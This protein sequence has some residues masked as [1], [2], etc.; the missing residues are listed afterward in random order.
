[1]AKKKYMTKKLKSEL[2]SNYSK[3]QELLVDLYEVMVYNKMHGNEEY[4]QEK[5]EKLI[6]FLS[7]EIYR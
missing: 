7:N 5:Y 2:S 1:M 3:A 4:Y 6:E